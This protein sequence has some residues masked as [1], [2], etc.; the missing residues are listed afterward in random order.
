MISLDIHC[1]SIILN[2][3]ISCIFNA[4]CAT[5]MHYN[6]AYIT[7]AISY[8]THSICS[9]CLFSL[10]FLR[11]NVKILSRRFHDEQLNPID[12]AN[13]W[14]EYIIKYGK[15]VLRSPAMD[16]APWQLH[17]IDVIAFL[18]LCVTIIIIIGIY[19]LYF[20]RKI[21]NMSHDRLL[22]LKK[23]N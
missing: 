1:Y 22:Y 7:S 8:S 20:L 2:A 5:F 6:F 23:M 18:L 3:C 17:L 15:D 10:L 9:M 16:L 4:R 13:Y 21:I 19:L 12:N 11:E 14:I